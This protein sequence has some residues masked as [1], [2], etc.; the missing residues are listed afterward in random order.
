M[1]EHF[2]GAHTVDEGGIHMADDAKDMAKDPFVRDLAT[3]VA[4]NQRIE[5]NEYAQLKE[6]LSRSG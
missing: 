3:R 4:R 5:I 1:A 2:F 6:R